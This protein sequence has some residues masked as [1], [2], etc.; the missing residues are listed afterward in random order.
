MIVCHWPSRLTVLRPS[1]FAIR[2]ICCARADGASASSAIRR[3]KS[4]ID[5]AGNKFDRVDDSRRIRKSLDP[6]PRA[7]RRVLLAVGTS[8]CVAYTRAADELAA[9]RN[10]Q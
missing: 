3:I 5:L 1:V 2:S 6:L 9:Y 4:F 8:D 7:L 10:F